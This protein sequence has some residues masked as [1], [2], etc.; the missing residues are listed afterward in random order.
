[1]DWEQY[2]VVQTIRSYSLFFI[3]EEIYYPA[4]KHNKVKDRLERR[5]EE[6]GLL[7]DGRERNQLRR[8]RACASLNENDLQRL[9]CFN[10]WSPIGEI[11][12]EVFRGVALLG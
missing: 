3:P 8:F 1:M 6:S 11:V 4:K 10:T 9:I 5:A 7:E 12:W 2:Y